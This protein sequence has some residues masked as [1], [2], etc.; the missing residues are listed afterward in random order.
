MLALPGRAR[1]APHR[2]PRQADLGQPRPVVTPDDRTDWTRTRRSQWGRT[3]AAETVLRRGSTGR[4]VYALQIALDVPDSSATV[5]SDGVRRLP[6]S[7][8][9]ADHGLARNAV[10]NAAVWQ[11]L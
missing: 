4:A 3:N 11:A 2:R 8:F 6:W 10:V 9:K 7:A 5:C 1:P